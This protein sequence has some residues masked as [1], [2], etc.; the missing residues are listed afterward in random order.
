MVYRRKQ[1]K[2]NGAERSRLQA[3]LTIKNSPDKR[4]PLVAL[5]AEVQG[6]IT[7]HVSTPL[8][9]ANQTYQGYLANG[10]L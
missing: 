5:P 3:T 7:S 1:S 4:S 10:L 9:N 8:S 2:P 6:I